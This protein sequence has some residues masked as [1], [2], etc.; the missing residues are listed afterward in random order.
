MKKTTHLFILSLFFSL[1]WNGCKKSDDALALV[2][3][4][5]TITGFSPTSGTEGTSVTITGTNFSTTS[6]GNTVK[7]NGTAA[8]I[9]TATATGLTVSVRTGASTGK[10]TVQ[11]G[12]QT[13]TSANDFIVIPPAPPVTITGFSPATGAAGTNVTITG[14]NFSSSIINNLVKFNG[15]LALVTAATATSLTVSVPE[16]GSTGK[17]TVQVGSQTATSTNDFVF[18]ATIGLNVSTFAGSG[19]I[20]LTNAI[21][22][23]AKFFGP[24]AL[25]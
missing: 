13:A 3:S 2:T 23:A 7:F 6:S 10:I 12:S 18:D 8:T 11:V 9:L 22:T 25:R 20:G 14:T 16:D 15:A 24:Q 17:I 5:P 19:E 1:L 21:G 4:S